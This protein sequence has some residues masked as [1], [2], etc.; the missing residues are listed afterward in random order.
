M[1]KSVF[2]A[3]LGTRCGKKI[4]D[5]FQANN[6][7]VI[8]TAVNPEKANTENPESAFGNSLISLDWNCSSPFSS[9]NIILGLRKYPEV[10]YSIIVFSSP[11]PDTPLYLQGTADIQKGFDLYLQSQIFITRELIA[12]L[13]SQKTVPLFMVLESGDINNPY[14]NFLKSFINTILADQDKIEIP[15]NAFEAD[16]ETPEAFADYV[17]SA[18]HEKAPKSRGK[19]LRQFNV[20]SLLGGLSIPGNRQ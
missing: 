5:T 20:H 14:R 7:R 10:K 16:R 19:W 6:Y 2:I 11:Q 13:S 18:I 8:K 3:D 9:K 17:Y 12:E 1:E 15:V 4:S